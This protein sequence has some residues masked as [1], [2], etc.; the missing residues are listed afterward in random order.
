[1][2]LYINKT[3]KAL[4]DSVTRNQPQGL[5]LYG[6]VGVGLRTVAESYAQSFGGIITT[7]LPEKNE[8]IDT[9]KGVISIDSVRRLYSQTRTI[10][11]KGRVIII[12]FAEKMGLP[13]Q[14][15]FLKLLEE[16]STGTHF[17]L[18][19]HSPDSLLPTILSRVQQIEIKPISSAESE[20]LID[21]LGV[22]DS[23]KQAQLMFIAD[24]LPAELTRLINDH[25]YFSHKA[26][27][28]KDAR[29]FVTGTGYQKLLIAKKYKDS[30][31]DAL[32]LVE[33][34]L[35]QVKNTVLKSA[36]SSGSG[37]EQ[38]INVLDKLEAIHKKLTEQGNVRL[39][40][41][42]VI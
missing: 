15:A 25:E 37:Y 13:A 10:E 29:E 16:P 19:S 6:K 7:V 11:P 32:A 26:G 27:V 5:L 42:S 31:D 9:E 35:K 30:R 12:D 14:N 24:G 39:Q 34:S 22:K 36:T 28:V 38:S 4:L 8:V 3:S 18:L 1:M 2:K 40:L 23:R 17:I 20:K 33:F 41:S 21:S